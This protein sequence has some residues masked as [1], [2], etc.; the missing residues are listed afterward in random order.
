MRK[1]NWN[2]KGLQSQFNNFKNNIPV[3]IA[4]VALN[5]F[6]EGFRKGGYQTDDSRSGW[7]GR[8][9]RTRRNIGRALL[10]NTGALRNDILRREVNSKRIVIGTRNI[11]YASVH[12][13]GTERMPKRE[14]LG[15]STVLNNKITSIIKNKLS[16][17]KP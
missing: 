8:K 13:E 4:N 11:A 9:S 10:V 15:N 17:I 6:L 16:K 12:N 2:I 14:F 3:I 7:A 5:H 1:G